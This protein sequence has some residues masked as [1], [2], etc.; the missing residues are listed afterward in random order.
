MLNENQGAPQCGVL[1]GA[2]LFLGSCDDGL[3]KEVAFVQ[4]VLERG[5]F[6]WGGPGKGI[7][8]VVDGPEKRGLYL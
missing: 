8:V 7:A 1:L 4:I 2:I 5:S 6:L 3:K